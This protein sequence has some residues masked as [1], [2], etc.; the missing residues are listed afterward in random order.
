MYVCGCSRT[1]TVL[2]EFIALVHLA[3]TVKVIGQGHRSRTSQGQVQGQG[4]GKGRGRGRDQGQGQGQGQGQALADR[5]HR[6]GYVIVAYGAVSAVTS[7]VLGHVTD[8]HIRRA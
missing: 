3:V 4:R 5:V 8:T 7:L 6:I 2:L 1:S